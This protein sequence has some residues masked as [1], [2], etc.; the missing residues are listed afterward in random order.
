M[1]YTRYGIPLLSIAF[2]ASAHRHF[3]SHELLGASVMLLLLDDHC[4][5]SSKVG[6]SCEF[7][8]EEAF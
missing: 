5:W 6:A 1:H 2:H 8:E 4:S 3:H 7:S